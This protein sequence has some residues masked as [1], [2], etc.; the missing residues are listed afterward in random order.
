MWKPIRSAFEDE[1]TYYPQVFL[2]KV[3]LMKEKVN[4]LKAATGVVL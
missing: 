4:V 3:L 1:G 2:N